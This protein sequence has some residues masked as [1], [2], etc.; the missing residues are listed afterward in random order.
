MGGAGS[1]GVLTP[2]KLNPLNNYC[3]VTTTYSNPQGGAKNVQGKHNVYQGTGTDRDNK[4]YHAYYQWVALFLFMQGISFNVPHFLW[5]VWEDE[6]MDRITV[7]LRGRTLSVKEKND[8]LAVLVEYVSETFHLHNLYAFKFFFCELL[9]IV[10]V[11]GQVYLTDRFL[12]G[13]FIQ[14]GFD[15]FRWIGNDPEIR[16]DPLLRVFPRITIC[17]FHQYGPSG[18]I[19]IHNAM[20][21]LPQNNFNEKV[22]VTLWLWFLTLAILST[23]HLIY[24]VA[25]V[26]LT[27]LRRSLIERNSKHKYRGN[28]LDVLIHKAQIGDWFLLYLLS[29]N[30]DSILFKAFIGDLTKKLR[31]V[32]WGGLIWDT[33]HNQAQLRNNPETSKLLL[34][35]P[36]R[37]QNQHQKK[38]IQRKSSFDLINPSAPKMDSSKNLETS[39]L[40]VIFEDD[41]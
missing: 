19:E 15:V 6:K 12:G 23:L 1:H 28:K 7:T 4:V 29:L 34:S 35:T 13:S 21:L 14:Y 10:N 36:D 17:D 16:D 5:S 40:E 3:W 18:T 39:N 41:L 26:S 9:N 33:D 27:P 8:Q 2:D 30:L 37:S 24:V 32:K 20:C 11:I 38:S 22:F 25:V 31:P